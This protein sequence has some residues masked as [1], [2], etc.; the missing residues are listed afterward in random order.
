VLL[1]LAAQLLFLLL[2]LP[3]QGMGEG[4]GQPLVCLALLV[5]LLAGVVAG[6]EL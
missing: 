1:V 6:V 2:A 4:V 5:L 3:C